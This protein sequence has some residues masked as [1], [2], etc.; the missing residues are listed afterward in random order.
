MLFNHI[1]KQHLYN[2]QY[3]LIIMQVGCNTT[4]SSRGCTKKN[5]VELEEKTPFLL[6]NLK[7]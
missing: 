2:L 4:V 6:R 5:D 7:R 1:I 3:C